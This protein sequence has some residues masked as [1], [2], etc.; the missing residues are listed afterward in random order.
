MHNKSGMALSKN[1]HQLELVYFN[2]GN[3]V[4]ARCRF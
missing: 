1:I 3:T 4:T 2:V